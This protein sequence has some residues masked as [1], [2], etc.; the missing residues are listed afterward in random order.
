[1]LG[2][3]KIGVTCDHS[4]R[5]FHCANLSRDS[6]P[7]NEHGPR[8]QGWGASLGQSLPREGNG[9]QMPDLAFFRAHSARAAFHGCSKRAAMLHKG[10]DQQCLKNALRTAARPEKSCTPFEMKRE[11]SRI[12]K[13]TSEPM[14]RISSKKRRTKNSFSSPSKPPFL[15]TARSLDELKRLPSNFAA[16]G[17]LRV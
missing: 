11:S 7:L 4:S 8:R 6:N 12:S 16:M 5:F 14:A 17:R 15:G 2:G 9:W 1:M 10:G 3:R 13:A